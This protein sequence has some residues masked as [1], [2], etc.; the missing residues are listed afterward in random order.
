MS[1]TGIHTRD[2]FEFRLE[3]QGRGFLKGQERGNR[4]GGN[5]GGLPPRDYFFLRGL[6]SLA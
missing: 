2:Q 6:F 3:D 5:P 1:L 4:K